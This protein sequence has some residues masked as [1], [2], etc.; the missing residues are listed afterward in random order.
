ME[1]ITAGAPEGGGMGGGRGFHPGFGGF[2]GGFGGG[3]DMDD[4][5]ASEPRISPVSKLL[6]WSDCSRDVMCSMGVVDCNGVRAKLHLPWARKCACW[7]ASLL[8][9]RL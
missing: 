3:V 1:E 2:G 9:A 5:F 8:A 4:I 6:L 7:R